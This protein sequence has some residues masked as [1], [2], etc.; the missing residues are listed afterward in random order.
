MYRIEEEEFF[1]DIYHYSR[2]IEGGPLGFPEHYALVV[3]YFE[4]EEKT[5]LAF[6]KLY[7]AACD[8]NGKLYATHRDLRRIHLTEWQ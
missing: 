1:V 4:D 6:H 5:Q 8:A 7:E 3:E 2:K